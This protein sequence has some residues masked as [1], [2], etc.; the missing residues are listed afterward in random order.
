MQVTRQ[1]EPQKHTPRRHQGPWRVD[2]GLN[3]SQRHGSSLGRGERADYAITFD[4]IP[5]RVDFESRVG[6]TGR[7]KIVQV[8]KLS[9][10]VSCGEL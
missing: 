10:S 3:F 4:L 6:N 9:V 7:D 8:S 5:I 1:D 2:N